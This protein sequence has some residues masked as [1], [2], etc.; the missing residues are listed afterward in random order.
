[1]STNEKRGADYA[2]Q[3]P[4]EDGDSA[5]RRPE[6][7][8]RPTIA[9]VKIAARGRCGDIIA[10]LTPLSSE[11]LSKGRSDHPCTVCNSKSTIWPD[12]RDGGANEHGRV[13]C[14]N[15]TDD[16]PT[17][18]IIDTVATFAGLGSQG[19]SAKL[20]ADY[21]GLSV[22]EAAGV[23]PVKLDLVEAVAKAKRMPVDAFRQFGVEVAQRVFN[24]RKTEVVRV[25]VYNADGEVHSHFDMT[26]KDKGFFKRGVGN[27]GLLFPGRLPKPGE[28]WM[29][30]EG[31]EDAAALVGMGYS[32]CGLNTSFLSSKYVKLFAGVHIITVADLDEPGQRGAAKTGGNLVGIAASVKAA[33]LP[34]EIVATKGDD[35]RDCIARDGVDSV[36]DAIDNA[37]LWQPRDG[38]PPKDDRPE[39]TLTLRYAWH[40]DQV[41][42]YLG[43]LGWESSWIPERKRESRKLYQRGGELVEAVDEVT[44]DATV[45][46]GKI[47]VAKGTP[48]IR[49]LPIQQ[50]PLRI[51]D[52]CQ[53]L[54]EREKNEEL[55]V[56]AV[57]PPRWLVDGIHTSGNYGSA[58]RPLDGIVTAPTLRIDGSILQTPG[59]DRQT[60]LLFRPSMSFAKVPENP[61][62]DEAK[63][64]GGRLIGV[65][66][67]FPFFTAADRSA[68]LTM[69]LSM[70]GRPC[71]AGHVPLF[72]TTANIRGAG[73]S[74][75]VDVASLIAY[76][77]GAARTP[78]TSDDDE[79]R[80]RITAIAIE[81]APAVLLDNIDR[82]IGGAALD[83]ALTAERWKDRELQHSRNIDL[84]M[85]AVWAATGN[86]LQ[87]R[88]DVARRVLPIRLDSPL[89]KPEERT[90][91]Q[92]AD[93]L[94]W[95]RSHRGELVTDALTILRAYFV[96]GCPVQS[97]GTFGSFENWSHVIRGAVVW[98]GLADPMDTR[99]TAEADDQSSAIVRGLMGGL[100]EIDD[101][102]DG[103]TCREI[104]TAMNGA[105]I[106]RYP[107]MR[108]VIAESA[109][110]RG[111]ADARKLGY[112]LRR[113]RGRVSGGFRLTAT[114]A[115]GGRL[116]WSAERVRGGDG[117][118]G[119]DTGEHSTSGEVGK[120][121]HEER[122][123]PPHTHGKC[124]ETSQPSPPS[125]PSEPEQYGSEVEL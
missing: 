106:D 72:A 2:D 73:K 15:C 48:R 71:I 91:F 5:T 95:V 20:I 87:F 1:M 84:P 86:N 40:C 53:L 37:H 11:V 78:Y 9:E 125:Q 22:S 24:G 114:T 49:A 65:V 105:D 8:T 46:G 79:M 55:V 33:R 23:S 57:P 36:R 112:V 97:G 98:A 74:M 80:K 47:S 41:T 109:T 70:I 32:A 54:I 99:E 107:T 121:S 81:A 56:E 124:S 61:S 52:A 118:D 100:L 90:G 45:K 28:I 39:E 120:N 115:H 17:G 21:L 14:R 122:N 101:T 30:V 35:V 119:G 27:S 75:L 64:A 4:R 116:S 44:T 58:V 67:D 25:P 34:G 3:R 103:M 82:P 19:E 88:S 60:G 6:Y 29:L 26:S 51:A 13:A 7:T 104:I 92:H 113:Y 102:G 111:V 12:D 16:K 89:E 76:G 68:W 69:L 83:A 38:E 31:V 77:H 123:S 63:A 66:A 50:L 43:K 94:G 59:W 117:C 93:L 42:K 10:A 108:E 18:D 110:N 85:K 62:R 96:A